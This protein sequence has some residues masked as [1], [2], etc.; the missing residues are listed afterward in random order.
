L[1]GGGILHFLAYTRLN[2]HQRQ[3]FAVECQHLAQTLDHIEGFEQVLPF[4]KGIVRRVAGIIRQMTGIVD[5]AHKVADLLRNAGAQL[6]AGSR[7]FEMDQP[8]ILIGSDIF[9][10]TRG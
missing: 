9:L 6:T 10:S 7:A 4:F 3:L 2:I 5:A 8:L 1:P